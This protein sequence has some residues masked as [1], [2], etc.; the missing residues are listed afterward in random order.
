MHFQKRIS[1]WGVTI[2]VARLV[3]AVVFATDLGRDVDFDAVLALALA[4]LGAL[5]GLVVFF[6]FAINR[7]PTFRSRIPS[8]LRPCQAGTC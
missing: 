5:G 6:F 8:Q 3:F 1:P 4:F 7:A 2:T